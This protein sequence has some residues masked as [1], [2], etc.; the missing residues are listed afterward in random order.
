M[1]KLVIFIVTDIEA[2]GPD[3]GRHSMLSF[4]S[5]ARGEDGQDY[6][7]FFINLMPLPEAEQARNN[8]MVENVP[9]SMGA[10]EKRPD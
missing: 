1:K 2:D 6:G 5:V 7:E 8:A 9:S 10:D 3:P 4:A